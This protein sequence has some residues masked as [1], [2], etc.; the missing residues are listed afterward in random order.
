MHDEGNP[1]PPINSSSCPL[2][3]NLGSWHEEEEQ[4]NT[5]AA[6]RGDELDDELDEEEVVHTSMSTDEPMPQATLPMLGL[7]QKLI[8]SIKNAKLEDDIKDPK[9]IH[10]LCHPSTENEP[11]DMITSISF[12]VF[13]VLV[14]G[15]EQINARKIG[16]SNWNHANT[17]RH[18]S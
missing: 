15:S 10:S 16:K 11:L 13:N 14:G 7:A 1:S 4:E 9:L 6:D 12:D 17:D 3:I 18:V 2:T 8:D 5:G